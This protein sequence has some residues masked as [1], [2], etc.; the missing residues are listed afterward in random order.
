M[1][2]QQP[3][4]VLPYPPANDANIEISRFTN[5]F[6]VDSLSNDMIYYTSSSN[7]HMLF[8]TESNALSIINMS[9]CNVK[10]N[11]KLYVGA[12]QPY[13]TQLAQLEIADANSNLQLVLYTSSNDRKGM[14]L[15]SS[16]NEGKIS[17]YDWTNNN[18][19]HITLQSSGSN[20]GIGHGISNPVGLVH[21]RNYTNCNNIVIESGRTSDGNNEGIA[22]INFNGFSSNGQRRIET[23]K[24]RWRIKVDQ[25]STNE[26]MQ[27]D[28]Y[29]GTD[30]Y[31]Y[32]TLS[33]LNFGINRANPVGRL[34][35]LGRTVD[36]AGSDKTNSS[37]NPL[38]LADDSGLP[39]RIIHLNSNATQSAIYNYETNKNIYWGEET[40]LGMYAYR[41]RF[42]YVQSNIVIGNSNP[43]DN[44][45]IYAYSNSS[46]SIKF[47]NHSNLLGIHFGIEEASQLDGGG[48]LIYNTS[49]AHLKFG[50]NNIE[51]MRIQP[52]GKVN[53]GAVQYNS[54]QNGM[55]ELSDGGSNNQF[56]LYNNSNNKLGI[57]MNTSNDNARIG[58]W[59]W[60]NNR[61]VHLTFQHLGS[62]IGMGLGLSNPSSLLHL[63]NDTQSNN[64]LFEAGRYSD[65]TLEGVSAINFNGFTSNGDQFIRNTKNRYRIMVNQNS[66]SEFMKIDTM[67]SGTSTI[68][69]YMVMSNQN[70][71]INTTNPVGRLQILGRTIESTTLADRTD[72]SNNPLTLQ[73]DSGQ[74]MRI[75]HI[76]THATQSTIYNYQT[77]KD[78]YW[79]Q[80]NDTGF[81]VFKGRRTVVESNMGIN[82]SN[83]TER[84][85]IY[86]GHIFMR[87]D[88]GGTSNAILTLSNLIIQASN[89]D[90][91]NSAYATNGRLLWR[92]ANVDRMWLG[93][94]GTLSI[95]TSAPPA[96]TT[97]YST[98]N[99][100]APLFIQLDNTS[101][102]TSAYSS[103]Y[104]KN[105]T[106]GC[107]LFLNSS[108]RTSDGP[109]NGATLRNDAGDLRLAAAGTNPYIYLQS[110]TGRVGIK[111]T[112]PSY[113][114]DVVG[115]IAAS[116]DV[117]VY[118]DARLKSDLQKIPSALDKVKQITGY[119]YKRKDITVDPDRRHVGVIAQDVQKVLP[120]AVSADDNGN[121]SVAYGNIIALLIE[122][123]KELEQKISM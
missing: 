81:Y 35:V 51:R 9:A 1:P 88:V 33:N 28:S 97:F 14:Y 31:N 38:T 102:G 48:G 8:G 41:G 109:A 79:G 115:K 25:T 107:M 29:N 58:G 91:V 6:F 17:G 93:S 80:S 4:H 96:S 20:L 32:M 42:L 84:L 113:T 61:S 123:I 23:T 40:D 7:Q 10:I 99:T 82:T 100:D 77:G 5:Y 101:A 39:M 18:P 111:T 110:S 121:L 36:G 37:N 3:V 52:N 95:N 112:T 118:S 119:T 27:I 92:T 11:R 105:N 86:N 103:L 43:N 87:P 75:I 46:N 71:G 13:A 24:Q 57:Y 104:L 45:A 108:G 85:N 30:I 12:V 114:L 21:M 67:L 66:T 83:L 22:I 65:K 62:N 106:S 59:D 120:E 2:H 98:S 16:N 64:I 55:L 70:I 76:N 15:I 49:N 73:D 47:V 69:N 19:I 116:E 44:T 34:H 60:T 78:V 122:A 72:S 63:A 26:N 74:P 50:T 90:L 53:I 89:A 94:N 56:I 54:I 117:Y 68:Y